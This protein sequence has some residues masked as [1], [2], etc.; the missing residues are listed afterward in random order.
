MDYFESKQIERLKATIVYSQ[1]V[2]KNSFMLN[3]AAAIAIMT[4]AG[5]LKEKGFDLSSLPIS[6]LLFALGSLFAVLCGFF[7]YIAQEQ[8]AAIKCLGDE[9][10]IGKKYRM[11]SKLV[12][13]F[14]PLCFV[15]GLL[16]GVI[17]F[18]Q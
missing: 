8:L 7:A 4:Y 11:L 5:K 10:K 16:V 9:K 15:A 13:V 2:I 18:W 6:L 12:G 17:Y 14:S 3:G 1:N